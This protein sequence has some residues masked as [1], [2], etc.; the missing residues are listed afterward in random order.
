MSP[1]LL[2]GGLASGRRDFVGSVCLIV[3]LPSLSV[4]KVDDRPAPRKRRIASIASAN[5]G[6]SSTRNKNHCIVFLNTANHRAHA[7]KNDRE[8]YD[9]YAPLAGIPAA[10][11]PSMTTRLDCKG[12]TSPRRPLS[13]STIQ[14]DGRLGNK[15]TKLPRRMS[16]SAAPIADGSPRNS[17]N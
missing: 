12:P 7:G 9:N 11:G 17:R 2:E 4:D 13:H 8:R 3:T 14:S 15:I 6:D 1:L 16:T 10:T 5:T